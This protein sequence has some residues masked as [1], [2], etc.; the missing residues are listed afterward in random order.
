M[1]PKTQQ[2]K[3]AA[4]KAKKEWKKSLEL[5][6]IEARVCEMILTG[7]VEGERILEDDYSVYIGY[8]YVTDDNGGQVI[9]SYI[10]GTVKDLKRHI[11]EKSSY[12]A[13]NIYNCNRKNRNI[14]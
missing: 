7:I 4:K 13:K 14:K 9:M 12:S 11:R 5:E 3:D 6:Q 1:I 2:E 10:N 8:T